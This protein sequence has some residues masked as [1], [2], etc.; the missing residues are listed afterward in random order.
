LPMALVLG[1]SLSVQASSDLQ[2]RKPPGVRKACGEKAHLENS[3]CDRRCIRPLAIYSRARAPHAA[4]F[5]STVS[6]AS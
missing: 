6:V 1:A 3:P 5:G 4:S 2:R